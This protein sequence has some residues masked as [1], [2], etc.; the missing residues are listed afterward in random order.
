[1]EYSTPLHV[2]RLLSQPVNFL[3]VEVLPVYRPSPEERADPALFAANVRQ[4]MAR[5]LGVP[6]VERGIGEEHEL[7]ARGIRPNIWGS[8]VVTPPRERPS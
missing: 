1:M 4:V 8:K 3:S 2:W 5:R 6:M 7:L